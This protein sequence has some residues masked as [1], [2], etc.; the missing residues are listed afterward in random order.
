MYTGTAGKRRLDKDSQWQLTFN[1]VK[2]HGLD[3]VTTTAT[4]VLDECSLSPGRYSIEATTG[5]TDSSLRP[6]DQDARKAGANGF[7]A[8]FSVQGEAT[9]DPCSPKVTCKT[10]SDCG[11]QASNHYVCVKDNSAAE[12][13]CQALPAF[14]NSSN[15]PPGYVCSNQTLGTDGNLQGDAN[16]QCERDC[17]VSD[18]NGGQLSN[19][20]LENEVCD[21]LTG[22][23]VGTST[24][25]CTGPNC[26]EECTAGAAC[27]P[28]N[29]G[30]S[31]FSAFDNAGCPSGTG[32]D[33]TTGNCVWCTTQSG[34]CMPL[35]DPKSGQATEVGACDWTRSYCDPYSGDCVPFSGSD[36]PPANGI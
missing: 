19:S 2:E 7:V 10:D 12:G 5:I 22:L 24:S 36:I 23:C 34:C 25:T 28:D 9:A 27:D 35:D 11:D 20:C 21:E 16:G 6:L 30:V 4:L 31:C 1:S 17:R 13:S 3:E 32:C 8:T 33:T 14:C 15:C 26:A 29:T 18:E